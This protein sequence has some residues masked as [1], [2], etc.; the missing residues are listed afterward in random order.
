MEESII[1]KGFIDENGTLYLQD[2][3]TYKKDCMR[4]KNMQVELIL[5]EEFQKAS[6]N[7]FSYYKG[8]VLPFV[9]K[10]NHSDF[11]GWT[12]K[13]VDDWFKGEFLTYDKEIKYP[14]GEVK[15]V[16]RQY[17][18]S[19]LSKKEMSAYITKCLDILAREF[20]IHIPT[21]VTNKK[22]YVEKK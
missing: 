14:S 2:L 9:L 12:T 5:Q 13:D 4:K 6:S 1:H 19:T 20:D 18:L 21:N 3:V 15:I 17:E 10:A 8:I 11:E 22:Y 7:Q 16:K